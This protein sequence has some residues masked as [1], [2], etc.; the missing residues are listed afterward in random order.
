M[1]NGTRK[2]TILVVDDEPLLRELAVDRVKVYAENNGLEIQ[3]L[4]ANDGE[5]AL[6]IMT[7]L[8][9]RRETIDLVV[10]D[11]NMPRT[12]GLVLALQGRITLCPDAGYIICSTEMNDYRKEVDVLGAT[13]LNK[14]VCEKDFFAALAKYIHQTGKA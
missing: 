12:N 5:S 2:Y 11:V 4:Q 1:T 7:N 9:D 14:P 6:E 10:T 8:K 13:A 3:I